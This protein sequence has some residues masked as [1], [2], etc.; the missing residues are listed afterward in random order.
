MWPAP[1]EQYPRLSFGLHLNAYTRACTPPHIFVY[2]HVY[3]HVNTVGETI[4][5]H[6]EENILLHNSSFKENSPLISV[7][8]MEQVYTHT[9][10]VC[11]FPHGEAHFA[12][13]NGNISLGMVCPCA[14]AKDD[15]LA[16][17]GQGSR[18]PGRT[19]ETTVD[20]SKD[21]SLCLAPEPSCTVG[22]GK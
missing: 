7:Y 15:F 13:W 19:K 6:K 3:T 9:H 21:R 1:E 16:L 2:T 10:T 18:T 22:L 20:V 11:V 4:K 5:N 17:K 8:T 14:K 12:R